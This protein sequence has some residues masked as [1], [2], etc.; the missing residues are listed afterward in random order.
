LATGQ[1]HLAPPENHLLI[2]LYKNPKFEDFSLPKFLFLD[3]KSQV[4]APEIAA[5]ELNGV[6]NLSN[7][8]IKRNTSDRFSH[9]RIEKP[10]YFG[11]YHLE[12]PD[13]IQI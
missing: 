4:A 12:I 9:E 6:L 2:E 8:G 13:A 1:F 7:S 5:L 11:Q 3:K 10:G